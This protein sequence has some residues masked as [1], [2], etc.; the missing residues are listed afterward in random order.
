[1]KSY[2]W[3]C[4]HFFFCKGK[5]VVFRRKFTA[6]SSRLVD[7][8][9]WAEGTSSSPPQRRGFTVSVAEEVSTADVERERES[10]SG[11]DNFRQILFG[12]ILCNPVAPVVC[13][14]W[15]CGLWQRLVRV[16][17]HKLTCA[18]MHYGPCLID[19][20]LSCQAARRK[21]VS[22]RVLIPKIARTIVFAFLAA[23]KKRSKNR[24]SG[25]GFH[26][27]THEIYVHINDLRSG[28][29]FLVWSRSKIMAAEVWGRRP[30]LGWFPKDPQRA[31][32]TS[33][34]GYIIHLHL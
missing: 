6:R 15:P 22:L 32:S 2:F 30:T 19:H 16:I 17:G 34:W 4:L 25:Y 12:Y 13:G 23:K 21:T 20:R 29:G 33:A 7:P 27:G 1:M 10:A 9:M 14:C 26:P 11:G 28:L 31:D 3:G 5:V 8:A 24:G 18:I